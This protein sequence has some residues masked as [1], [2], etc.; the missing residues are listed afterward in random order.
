MCHGVLKSVKKNNSMVL[1][2]QLVKNQYYS[3]CNLTNSNNI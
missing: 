3:K 1:T 2:L